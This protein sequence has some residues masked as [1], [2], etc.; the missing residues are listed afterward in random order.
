MFSSRRKQ[1]EK[2]AQ[3]NGDATHNEGK[4]AEKAPQPPA[5]K[6]PVFFIDEAHKL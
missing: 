2:Q 3:Q 5:K 1:S 6:I 4:G